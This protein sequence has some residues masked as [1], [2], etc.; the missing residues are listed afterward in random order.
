VKKGATKY[1]MVEIFDGKYCGA[2]HMTVAFP[3]TDCG[4]CHTRP[5]Q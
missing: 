4:R 3:L 1:S 5:V 2:C